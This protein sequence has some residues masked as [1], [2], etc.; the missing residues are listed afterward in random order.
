M[1]DFNQTAQKHKDKLPNQFKKNAELIEQRILFCARKVQARRTQYGITWAL[2]IAFRDERNRLIS[3][4]IFIKAEQD[5]ETGK[6]VQDGYWNSIMRDPE[7]DWPSH[8]L[9][10]EAQGRRHTLVGYPAEKC[11]CRG[12]SIHDLEEEEYEEG[13]P[14]ELAL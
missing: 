10:M 14:E 4:D 8:S 3:Q 13:P 6:I 7:L 1:A 11:P 9:R 2:H 12:M 5:E